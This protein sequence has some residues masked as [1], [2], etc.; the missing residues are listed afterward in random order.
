MNRRSNRRQ[1]EAI[2]TG[3][4]LIARILPGRL[5]NMRIAARPTALAL[6]AL[7]MALPQPAM[8][9]KCKLTQIAK[10]P[11]VMDGS[12]ATIAVKINGQDTQLWLDSGFSSTSCPRPRQ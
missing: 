10:L 12:R 1:N 6:L 2:M 4:P 9:D 5:D 7:S 3:S 8:A 11:V